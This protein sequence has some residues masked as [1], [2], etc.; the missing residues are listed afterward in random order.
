MQSSVE[1]MAQSHVENEERSLKCI[2]ELKLEVERLQSL[3][4]TPDVKLVDVKEVSAPP[5]PEAQGGDKERL[6]FLEDK[7]RKMQEQ[8]VSLIDEN[9]NMQ[10]RIMELTSELANAVGRT[11]S[12]S[13]DNQSPHS[14]SGASRAQRRRVSVIN[15]GVLQTDADKASRLQSGLP[16]IRNEE[17]SFY[18]FVIL[19]FL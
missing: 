17:V 15:T 6:E 11:S 13:L 14:T 8:N 9:T 5:L 4:K 19:G 7:A 10:K 3:S 16:D 2:K 1:S 18:L 12:M